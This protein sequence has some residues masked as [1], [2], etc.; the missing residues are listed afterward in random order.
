MDNHLADLARAAAAKTTMTW[1]EIAV[2]IES[3]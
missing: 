1:E 3:S 2:Y